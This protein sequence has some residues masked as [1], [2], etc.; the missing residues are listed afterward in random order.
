[1]EH[2]FD[3]DEDTEMASEQRD[4]AEMEFDPE[5]DGDD[6]HDPPSRTDDSGVSEVDDNIDDESDEDQGAISKVVLS[7]TITSKK[8]KSLFK[9]TVEDEVEE[10]EEGEANAQEDSNARK[11]PRNC[12]LDALT[13]GL[14]EDSEK[15]FR[16]M[17][18]TE[19]AF[20]NHQEE[21]SFTTRSWDT[22]CNAMDVQVPMS[23][24]VE[25]LVSR[26]VIFG[27]ML[28]LL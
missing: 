5:A 14:A 16:V 20:P 26:A 12:D 18:A 11:R 15:Q 23:R 2:L 17:V 28:T 3:D 25:R 10:E 27:M 6:E 13:K 4:N 7:S 21:G 1:M 8:G 22:S 19:N 24:M 9:T